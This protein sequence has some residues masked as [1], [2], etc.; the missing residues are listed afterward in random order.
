M[1]TYKIMFGN[2]TSIIIKADYYNV[3][4]YSKVYEFYIKEVKIKKGV[5][6]TY[7]IF[8]HKKILETDGKETLFIQLMK[9]GGMKMGEW[10]DFKEQNRYDPEG[11]T[12]E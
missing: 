1:N 6:R 8:N 2:G 4:N 3:N 7:S 10:S 11:D 5:F 9:Q 12:S